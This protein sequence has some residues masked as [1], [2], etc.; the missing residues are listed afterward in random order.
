[1]GTGIKSKRG[2]FLLE[3]V[4]NCF[5]DNTNSE[6]MQGREESH[7]NVKLGP[8][9]SVRQEERHAVVRNE[10][11]MFLPETRWRRGVRVSYLR[12]GRSSLSYLH[13]FSRENRKQGGL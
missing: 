9:G 12:D 8:E 6:E 2:I 5:D 13:R 7:K 11:H 3:T 10:A 1:M 4:E